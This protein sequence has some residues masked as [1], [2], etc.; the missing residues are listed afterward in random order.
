MLAARRRAASGA[1][2]SSAAREIKPE[3][4][5]PPRARTPRASDAVVSKEGDDAFAWGRL[6]RGAGADADA[7]AEFV[8]DAADEAAGEDATETLEEELRREPLDPEAVRAEVNALREESRVPIERLLR[9]EYKNYELPGAA[10]SACDTPAAAPDGAGDDA[11]S[12][13]TSSSDSEDS[14]T[15]TDDDSGATPRGDGPRLDDPGDAPGGALLP[16]AASGAPPDQNVSPSSRRVS[17]TIAGM[18][19]PAP[20][21]LPPGAA[22][23]AYATR[24]E[25]REAALAEG[26]RVRYEDAVMDRAWHL[27]NRAPRTKPQPH[28]PEP[29]RN[30]THW[31][32]LLEEMRWL[33]GDF[34]R[35]RKFRAKLARKAAHAVARSNLDLESRVVK[36]AQD[37]LIAARKTAR[38]VA[39][40]VMHFWIK[41]EKVVRFKAQ[42]AIDAKRKTV[43][44]KH[45]DFLL[46]QTERYSTMLAA[47]LGGGE[48]E[49]GSKEDQGGRDAAALEG[50]TRAAKGPIEALPAPGD[51]EDKARRGSDGSDRTAEPPAEGRVTRKEETDADEEEYRADADE[52]DAEDDEATLEEEMRRAE[53]EGEDD[54]AEKEAADLAADAEVPVEELLR[55]YREM[56]EKLAAENDAGAKE[57]RDAAT[58]SVKAEVEE[59][60]AAPEPTFADLAEERE[61]PRAA[62]DEYVAAPGEDEDDEATLEEEMRRAEAE[63]G[64][65][66][67]EK[68]AA[69]LAA[70]AEI[71][72]E[73]LM[74]R[75]REMEARDAGEDEDEEAEEEEEEDAEKDAEDDA[76]AER[77]DAEA[78]RSDAEDDEPGV[79]ALAEDFPE[80]T[81]EERAASAARRRV[82]DTLAGDAGAIQPKGHTL[83]AAEVKCRVPFLLKHGLREYQHVGLNWLVSCYDKALNGIL[84]D[85][86]GLGKTIQ[87]I[88][89]LAYLA[90]ERGIW[91]PHLIVV[92]TSVMLNWEVEFKK[93]APAFKLLTY[94]GTAKERK[95]KRQGWSKPNSFHVCVTTYRLI[96]QDARVFRRK[97]WKYLIL[98]E[99]HMIKNWRS[100]RWQTLL[101]FNSKRRLLITGTPLQNDL[102]ELWSLMHFLMPHV[103]QSHSEFKNWFSSPLTGMVEG[104]EGVNMGLVNRLHGVLRPFLLRRLKSEVEKNLPGKTEHVVHCGLS[105]RQRRLYEEYMAS[106]DTS[107]TLQSGNLLGIINCLMQLR[108]V[109]NHPDLF[110]GRPIVS[111]FDM[112]PGEIELRV[113]SCVAND[114]HAR[115]AGSRVD[116][117]RGAFD[118]PTSAAFFAARG[119]HLLALEDVNADDAAEA[120]RRAVSLEDVE[121]EFRREDD[122]EEGD[123]E[124]MN[125]D[126]RV[127]FRERLASDSLVAPG[128]DASHAAALFR[129]ARSAARKE[130]RRATLRRLAR[131]AA[132]A[133]RRFVPVYGADLRRAVAI[134]DRV[135]ECHA[136]AAARGAGPFASTEALLGAVKTSARRVAES[137]EAVE[138][139]LFA[140]PRA[141]A[142]T[143]AMTFSA[144]SCSVRA[145]R[146]DVQAW[147]QRVGW[148]ALAPARKALVR[149]QLFFPDRRLVQFDC[150]KLQALATL[151]RRLKS[152]GHKVLIF[153]QMTKMLDI[154]EA[155]LNLYGYPY[156]RLD[157]S[158]RPEQ[159]QILMQRF[160]TDPRLFAFILSTRSGGFGIN[161]TG[162]DTVVF[163]DSDWN[164]AMDQQAQD[165]AHRIGQTREVHIYRMV[166]KGTIEENILKKS[167]QKR[168]LDHFAIQAGNF[169]TEHFEKM[170]GERAKG[171]GGEADDREAVEGGAEGVVGG[172]DGAAAM[173]V[174]D[175]AMNHAGGGGSSRRSKDEDAAAADDADDGKDE[176]ARLMDEAQDDVDKAAFE[177][178]R[179]ED[180]AEAAE[181]GDDIKEAADPDA[182]TDEG[183]RTLQRSKSASEMSAG[184]ER[185]SGDPEHPSSKKKG[186]SLENNGLDMV[187]IDTSLEGDDQFAQDMMRKVQA[188]AN[189][190]ESLEQQLAPIERYAVRYLEETVRILDDVDAT[191]T[192]V[193]AY[194]EKEWEIEQLEKQKQAAEAAEDDDEL[195]IEGWETSVAD[196]EYRRRVEQATRE[197]EEERE[198]LR[199]ERERWMAM[200]A[201]PSLEAEF[202]ADR[203]GSVPGVGVSG[204]DPFAPGVP[205]RSRSASPAPGAAPLRVT[206]RLGGG[207]VAAP[208]PSGLGPGPGAREHPP[209]ASTADEDK[210]KRARKER[211]KE[212]KRKRREAETPAEREARKRLRRLSREGAAGEGGAEK[213]AEAV[214]VPVPPSGTGTGTG[215]G[216]TTAAALPGTP[217]VLPGTALPGPP[218]ASLPGTPLLSPGAAA[219]IGPAAGP[220]WLPAE[221]VALCATVDEFGG[222]SWA[223]AAHAISHAG[224]HARDPHAC[225]DRFRRVVARRAADGEKAGTNDAAAGGAARVTP[226]LTK[227]LLRDVAERAFGGHA[228]AMH[229]I[230]VA[231]RGVVRAVRAEGASAEARGRL[232]EAARA[233]FAAAD[234]VAGGGR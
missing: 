130:A 198:R 104:G 147:G 217:A 125:L 226:E 204:G 94:F 214:P 89:L 47:K 172:A 91:G 202:G 103:F 26:A 29:R 146:R 7:D 219:A 155:F 100:Q 25:A 92:P 52:M 137:A 44:D 208:R 22:P 207:P 110:A 111:S 145:W 117:K 33:A 87:T 140:I 61:E 224:P 176:V 220:A 93:W 142:P 63:G 76:E 209:G 138:H 3:P 179:R 48:G 127:A 116:S 113:P 10:P 85:E 218:A 215:T 6:E 74:R 31:D 216:T 157:G 158:T 136:I 77:S 134:R 79:G 88:S 206:F 67:A 41:V 14:S 182:E 203:D 194:E 164:P 229:S 51:E 188:S 124:K 183:G 11:Y 174:F 114:A 223:L 56:E 205:R 129:D 71:P 59:M 8:L 86:M 115:T 123:S 213:A 83:D 28:F 82:L 159:R 156:C 21:P 175:R 201:V 55:R 99:A 154:L 165:R 38:N 15:A 161:L 13:D 210:D 166:C 53:A 173:S 23:I 150:G 49:E 107:A 34:V 90:C 141:R 109:C 181:F 190:G 187:Q 192:A 9:S 211:R 78:E 37:E 168:E 160:N 42:S 163:Y 184:A 122:A 19:R 196:D 199:I 200:Y 185:G 58:A 177:A 70:D 139:F 227:A 162:A 101:N 80:M 225:K 30:K 233:L 186:S 18:E 45:L 148:P 234:A 151:L 149:Q 36:R 40:E 118:D 232:V 178:T 231:F 135:G 153:T 39:N 228:K 121:A 17:L 189:R 98:D 65:E 60:D 2:P 144:P 222:A 54:D 169:N 170:R 105:K 167:M 191:A 68:E 197:A 43:M 143:I 133:A 112:F 128:P 108:K 119:L 81:A 120:R 106:S 95:L 195:I 171:P 212:E 131:R 73:E 12:S 97:K 50:G 69:D 16:N 152:G 96:T 221:D 32:H 1:T 46:G 132:D 35:E 24:E 126:E 62:D 5:R 57:E 180:E 75:Y 230:V 102:M 64:D 27:L 20:S 4:A 84:A 66:D 193:A 72:I